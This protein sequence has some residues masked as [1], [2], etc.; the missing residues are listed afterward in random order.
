MIN[1]GVDSSG[2]RR[3]LH[4]QFVH[5]ERTTKHFLDGLAMDDHLV[6]G[7]DAEIGNLVLDD[8]FLARIVDSS[9][10]SNCHSQFA[11]AHYRANL[12]I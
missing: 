8:N 5:T 2:K 4:F 9:R 11:L 12:V 7:L 10:L 6:I 3:Q 1:V